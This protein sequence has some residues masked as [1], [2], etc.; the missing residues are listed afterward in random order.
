MHKPIDYYIL[1]TPAAKCILKTQFEPSNGDVHTL[2]DFVYAVE[3]CANRNARKLPCEKDFHYVYM[4]DVNG[5][6]KRNKACKSLVVDWDRL[7]D[8]RLVKIGGVQSHRWCAFVEKGYGYHS[9]MGKSPVKYISLEQKRL[10]DL[11]GLAD[12]EGALAKALAQSLVVSVPEPEPEQPIE[13]PDELCCPISHEPFRDP[14]QTIRGMTYE[15]KSIEDWFSECVERKQPMTDPLT[16]CLLPSAVL[17]DDKNMR[18]SV[19]A[20]RAPGMTGR[21]GRG[22][23]GRGRGRA[24]P[25]GV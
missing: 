12:E 23:G 2:K 11:N 6:V 20:F 16:N 21:G 14:V 5:F 7:G 4:R 19:A 17:Y 10:Q 3:R 13:Y 1:G 9:G 24:G 22:R 25:S 18:F 8:E 15:R